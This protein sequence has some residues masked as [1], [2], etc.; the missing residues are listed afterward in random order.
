M[1]EKKELI[2]SLKEEIDIYEKAEEHDL[3]FNIDYK[4]CAFNLYQL[5]L[6][7]LENN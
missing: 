7:Y 4:E 3:D 2:K 5:I 6:H 1:N